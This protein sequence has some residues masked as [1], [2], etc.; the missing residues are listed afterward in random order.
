MWVAVRV[1]HLEDAPLKP[2]RAEAGTGRT[3]AAVPQAKPGIALGHDSG[4][5][6]S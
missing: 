2:V 3:W 6:E 5:E 4:R 1:S